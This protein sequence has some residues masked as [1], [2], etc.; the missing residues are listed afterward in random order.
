M[1]VSAKVVVNVQENIMLTGRSNR[2]GLFEADHLWLDHVGRRSF[3]GF[4][5]RHRE[6]LFKD[7]DSLSCT[8]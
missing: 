7:E 8:A 3:Y 4:L 6:E 1:R 2:R 5:A